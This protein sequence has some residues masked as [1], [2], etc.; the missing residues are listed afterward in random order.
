M[1]TQ[2]RFFY[3]IEGTMKELPPFGTKPVRQFTRNQFYDT[4]EWKRFRRLQ[5]KRNPLCFDC[6]N[7]SQQVHHILKVKDYPHLALVADNTICLC[8]SCHSKRTQRGE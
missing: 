2:A 5:L 6:Q 4:K 7:L 3:F 1:S 8:S